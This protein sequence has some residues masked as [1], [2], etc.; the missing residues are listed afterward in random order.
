MYASGFRARAHSASTRL[1]SLCELRRA[2]VRRS[3]LPRR[4]KT[5]VS[6]LMDALISAFT[7]VFDA[8]WRRARN[9]EPITEFAAGFRVRHAFALWAEFIIGPAFGRTRWADAPE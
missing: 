3:G 1:R 5:G 2:Q 7:R 8:L 4:R 6:D 9:P